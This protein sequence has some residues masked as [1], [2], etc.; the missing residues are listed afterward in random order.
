MSYP[1]T[2]EFTTFDDGG[3]ALGLGALGLYLGVAGW[4]HAA[5]PV[6]LAPSETA[7]AGPGG[8]PSW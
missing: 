2:L 3:D 1:S 6:P 4:R 7:T 8:S 5:L